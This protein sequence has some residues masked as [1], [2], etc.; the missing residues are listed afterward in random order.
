MIEITENNHSLV[1]NASLKKLYNKG[2]I[3]GKLEPKDLYVLNILYNLINECHIT[4]SHEQRKQLECLYRTLYNNSQNICKVKT[5]KGYNVDSDSK[6]IVA[7]KGEQSITV[8]VAIVSYWQE[9]LGVTY[10]DILDLI[11]TGTYVQTKPA[12]TKTAFETGVDIVYTDIGL[13][14]FAINCS[15]ESQQY[16]L[17]DVLG[18]DVTGGFL[19]YYNV[20]LGLRIFISINIY[21][22]GTIN[23][24]IKEV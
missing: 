1:L 6:F 13:I 8:P 2:R 24:K 15:T 19:S 17:Y 3:N 20:D 9:P 5:V 16:A 14:T 12:S 4:I 10:Q 7:D 18:N 21:S 23:F 22:M 11:D